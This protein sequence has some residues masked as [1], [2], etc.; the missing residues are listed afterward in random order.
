[1]NNTFETTGGET[2][3]EKSLVEL[4][5]EITMLEILTRNLT[6]AREDDAK[7]LEMYKG[8]YEHYYQRV[9]FLER[10]LTQLRYVIALDIVSENTHRQ[11]NDLWRRWQATIHRWLSTATS[12]EMDDIPF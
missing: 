10:C 7:R 9:M 4:H 11:R 1:M 6:I 3:D 12:D 8:W 5:G 2:S